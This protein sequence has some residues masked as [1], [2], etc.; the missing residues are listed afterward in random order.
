MECD[1]I[2]T[3]LDFGSKWFSETMQKNRQ[4]PKPPE[5]VFK[6]LVGLSSNTLNKFLFHW[7]I[8][9]E[10]AHRG[11]VESRLERTAGLSQVGE[12]RYGR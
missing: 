7:Q 8:D 2:Q 1:G 4:H 6:P 9:N 12:I 3:D 10:I 5:K 11:Y